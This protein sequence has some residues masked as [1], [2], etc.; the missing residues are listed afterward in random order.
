M[1]GE[2]RLESQ[3]WKRKDIPERFVALLAKHFAWTQKS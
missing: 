3:E 2:K 1:V